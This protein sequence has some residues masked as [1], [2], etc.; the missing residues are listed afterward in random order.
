MDFEEKL[1]AKIDN[2]EK[3][4]E[5]EISDLAF[6]CTF[7]KEE[8]ELRR[9]SRTITSYIKLNERFF[10]IEWE[11][12]LTEYQEDGFYNQPIEVV[13]HVENIVIPEHVQTIVTYKPLEQ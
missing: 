13:Q 5:S 4:S 1:L 8:G 9:W 3:L 12:G 11:E 10:K 2:K 7:D 6:Y